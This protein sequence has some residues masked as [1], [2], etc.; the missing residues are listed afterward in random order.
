VQVEYTITP[1]MLQYYTARR[2]FETEPGDFLAFVGSSSRDIV[3]CGKFT[4]EA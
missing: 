4:Y 3:E 2:I 1:E